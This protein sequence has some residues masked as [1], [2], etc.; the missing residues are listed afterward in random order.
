MHCWHLQGTKELQRSYSPPVRG[1]NNTRDRFRYQDLGNIFVWAVTCGNCGKGC[2][3]DRCFV[4]V[5]KVP[6]SAGC[7]KF[8][9]IEVPLTLGGGE[10]KPE[11][12]ELD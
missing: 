7:P 12:G 5:D 8:A 11:E 3:A 9:D 1:N 6:P 10:K 4:L 2:A